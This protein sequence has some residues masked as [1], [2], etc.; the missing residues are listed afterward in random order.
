MKEAMYSISSLQRSRC[1]HDQERREAWRTRVNWPAT[2]TVR[3]ITTFA[4]LEVSPMPSLIPPLRIAE[5]RERR[6]LTQQDLGLLALNHPDPRNATREEKAAARMEIWRYEN[7]ERI[8]SW[9]RLVAIAESLGCTDVHELL[10]PMPV[11]QW[12]R[13]LRAAER[14]EAKAVKV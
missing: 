2:F 12:A 11:R 10:G 7:G 1:L 8:P 9:E 14:A 6:G 13:K 3:A 5:L 4:G